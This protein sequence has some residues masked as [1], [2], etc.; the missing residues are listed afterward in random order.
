MSDERA[1][2]ELMIEHNR[3]HAEDMREVRGW[4]A[5]SDGRLS[6]LERTADATL[7]EA[8]RTNGRVGALE[9]WRTNH[10]Q[11][12]AHDDG[13]AEGRARLR[14]EDRARLALLLR[15]TQNEYVRL[16]LLA[17]GIGIVARYWPW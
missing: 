1:L 2:A 3:Q 7:A 12:V 15:V 13:I 14:A 9:G 4:M 8:R 17:G 6:A 10:D 5:S 16:A 11:R